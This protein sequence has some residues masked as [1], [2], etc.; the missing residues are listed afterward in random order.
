MKDF[1]SQDLRFP[2]FGFFEAATM[3][4]FWISKFTFLWIPLRSHE[5]LWIDDGNIANPNNMFRPWV[6]GLWAGRKG[7]WHMGQLWVRIKRNGWDTR[8]IA[9]AVIVGGSS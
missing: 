5:F 4:V 6:C 1:F 7:L 3:S 9:V 8:L 2:A